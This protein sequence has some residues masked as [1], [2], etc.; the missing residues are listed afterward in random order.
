MPL[1]PVSLPFEIILYFFL[2]QPIIVSAPGEFFHRKILKKK[3]IF[4]IVFLFSS[5]F[6]FLILLS[7]AVQYVLGVA[8]TEPGAILFEAYEK[9]RTGQ[10][11]GFEYLHTISKFAFSAEFFERLF[12]IA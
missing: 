12:L 5:Q 8:T 7:E 11:G 4:S 1:K 3:M 6:E 9:L 2:W 10:Y